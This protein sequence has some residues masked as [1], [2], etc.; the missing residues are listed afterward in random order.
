MA[1]VAPHPSRRTILC[2]EP[3]RARQRAEGGGACSTKR[4][5]PE[6]ERVLA[7]TLWSRLRPS[8]GESAL[9]L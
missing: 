2:C 9:D 5:R 7:E 6:E 8:I 3:R 1:S 4:V